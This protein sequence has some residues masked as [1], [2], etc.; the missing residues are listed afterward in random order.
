MPGLQK[1]LDDFVAER[2]GS[3][4]GIV[5]AHVLRRSALP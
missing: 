5:I 1:A 4:M 2:R 3:G